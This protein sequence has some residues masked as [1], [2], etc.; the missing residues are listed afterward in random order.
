MFV[1]KIKVL[2][3][4]NSGVFIN[5]FLCYLPQKSSYVGIHSVQHTNSETDTSVFH[6]E[7]RKWRWNN[8]MH[9]I[10][11]HRQLLRYFHYS[12]V[13]Y[14]NTWTYLGGS[15]TGSNHL[16]WI[17]YCYKNLKLFKKIWANSW[18][19]KTPKIIFCSRPSFKTWVT[20]LWAKSDARYVCP[21]NI[22]ASFFKR[23]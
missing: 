10:L 3:N 22:R 5:R 7:N 2:F 20:H 23:R 4:L 13:R 17:L 9:I 12:N 11:S 18:H 8:D 19:G 15:C 14:F 1:L 6:P 21:L 16:K